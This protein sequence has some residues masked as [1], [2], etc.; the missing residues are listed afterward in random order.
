MKSKT[1]DGSLIAPDNHFEDIFI[2]ERGEILENK[3]NDVSIFVQNSRNVEE[4][5]I[6]LGE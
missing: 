4:T 1:N 2:L 6:L 5:T 3:D